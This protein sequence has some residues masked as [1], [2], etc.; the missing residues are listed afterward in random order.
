MHDAKTI[1]VA[2]WLAALAVAASSCVTDNCPSG[3]V[4]QGD[5]CVRSELS[6]SPATRESS[7]ERGD[8]GAIVEKDAAEAPECVPKEEACNDS[9]DDCDGSIDE[10]LS[11]ACGSSD[12][13]PCKLGTKRCVAGA[14]G[15]CHG[16]IEP[17]E[18]VCDARSEDESCD[19]VSNE[20]C[21]CRQGETRACPERA[22]ICMRGQEKCVDGR[23]DAR[24]EGEVSGSA[25]LC[26]GEDNDCDATTDNGA[27][28]S[29]G[30]SCKGA[31]GCVLDAPTG[32]VKAALRTY[33][34]YYITFA[35]GGGYEG[36]GST[37]HTDARRAGPWE[38]FE[39][40]WLDD[41]YTKLAL[42][43]LNGY[44]LTAVEGGGIGGPNDATSPIHTDATAVDIHERLTLTITGS[45]VTIRSEQGYYL[46]AVD[47]GGLTGINQALHT[48]G[49]RLDIHETFTM[50][51]Q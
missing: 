51:R 47:G 3:S 35:D 50:E 6:R 24:C 9:D 46:T 12:I 27:L 8:A 25:E 31:Q 44:Y 36:G 19:G 34:G 16:A 30:T 37:V 23:W 33:G 11:M 13:A 39:L 22:G 7:Q 43:T 2:G 42:R 49:R 10:Q 18:E 41:K 32:E 45:Q 20:G 38:T 28:C 14:W 26:D 5:S 21:E 40:E 17:K 15:Q 4:K 1:H 48:H 29:A